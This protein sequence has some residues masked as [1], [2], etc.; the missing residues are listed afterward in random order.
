[1]RREYTQITNLEMEN[2]KL[3]DEITFLISQ[4]NI[5][6][7]QLS[8]VIQELTHIHNTIENA[9]DNMELGLLMKRYH[10]SHTK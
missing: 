6:K 3:K 4:L 1:M 5:T 7:E 2:S 8:K 9:S 10:L